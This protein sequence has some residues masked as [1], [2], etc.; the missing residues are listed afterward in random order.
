MKGKLLAFGVSLLAMATI[1]VVQLQSKAVDG[2]RDCD[3]FA[4]IRCGTMNADE[5][6]AEYDSNN[7]AGTNGYTQAQGDIKKVFTAMGISKA[8]LQGGFKQGVVYKNGNVEVDGKVVATNAQMAA[9]GLGGT[10]IAGTNAQKVSVSAMSDAQTAMVKLDQNGKFLYAVMKPC[11]NP[12]SATPKEE[13]KPEPKPIAKCVGLTVTQQ[14]RTKFS[15]TTTASAKDGAK[16]KG[17]NIKLY[18]GSDAIID[19]TYPST[20]ESQTVVYVV[21]TPGEYTVKAIVDTSEGPKQGKQCEATF[22]VTALPPPPPTPIPGVTITKHVDTD[23]KYARVNTNVAFSY[24]IDVT[25]TGNTDL[26]NVTVTDT[27]DRA[28]TLVSVMPPSTSPESSKIE[29]NSLVI[30]KL[31]LLKGETRTFTITAKVPVYVAGKLANTVCVDAPTVPG[32]PDKCDK[33]E[34][35]V[36]PAP[37]PGKIEVCLKNEDRF[38][39]INENEYNEQIHSKNPE[40]CKTPELP[41]ELPETGPTEAILS[42]VGAMSLVGSS[43]YYFASRRQSV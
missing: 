31:K 8:D 37:V 42:V 23:K 10:Q 18:R 30:S 2:N 28:I 38:V 9:R 25:N 16:I 33:A 5:L 26:D 29:N 1:G 24:K 39:Q 43:A 17:Y 20:T 12:V 13:P 3:Q 34:V 41:A 40:D 32:N 36:P 22:T 14:E 19:K 27:P 7:T 21:E 11:G 6:R 15:V 35:E 4:V